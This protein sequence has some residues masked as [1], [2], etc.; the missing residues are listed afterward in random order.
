M[1]EEILRLQEQQVHTNQENA[2][3]GEQSSLSDEGAHEDEAGNQKE[4]EKVEPPEEVALPAETVQALV[5]EIEELN[6]EM[7]ELSIIIQNA[8]KELML[9]QNK[10]TEV[11]VK[12]DKAINSGPSSNQEPENR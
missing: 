11:Q 5:S 9:L 12:L 8:S 1:Q 7:G 4:Y 3:L 2:D 10:L 6:L